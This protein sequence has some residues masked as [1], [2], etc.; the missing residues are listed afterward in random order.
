MSL[1]NLDKERKGYC[2]IA[3]V[4]SRILCKTLLRQFWMTWYS[5]LHWVSSFLWFV[6]TSNQCDVLR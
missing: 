3:A 2:C 5:P 6:P 1:N 4:S